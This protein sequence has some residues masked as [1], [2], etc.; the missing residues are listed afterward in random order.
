MKKRVT[1]WLFILYTSYCFSQFCFE[2]TTASLEGEIYNY[3]L[4]SC[5][6]DVTV[7][8]QTE[9]TTLHGMILIDALK[10]ISIK[11]T[12]NK[13][14]SIKPSDSSSFIDLIIGQE[15]IDDYLECGR[16]CNGNHK[17]GLKELVKNGS[18]LIYPN[19]VDATLYISEDE[20][21]SYYR[22]YNMEGK[23]LKEGALPT[24]N[25]LD[26]SKFSMGTYLLLLE[27]PT[28]IIVRKLYKN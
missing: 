10:S 27:T 7:V 9:N 20:N 16:A 13:T 2:T 14:I 17:V 1:S 6:S 25:Q 24:N 3:D 28:K 18:T 4:E 19:P 8:T 5:V 12:A 23:A 22:I 21:F 11:A 15:D 26:V